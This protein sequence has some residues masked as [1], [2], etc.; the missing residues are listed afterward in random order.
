MSSVYVHV[1]RCG[2]AFATKE[3]REKERH[4]LAANLKGERAATL[5]A[6]IEWKM[7]APE[8]E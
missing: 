1:K 3:A 8:N 4:F 2:S 5:F 6:R 7:N